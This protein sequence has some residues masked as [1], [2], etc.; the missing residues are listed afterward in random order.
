MGAVQLALFESMK[1][2]VINSRDIDFDVN[3]LL[4]EAL[5]GS[6]GGAIGAFISTPG[7]IVTIQL[8]AGLDNKDDE[9]DD[10]ATDGTQFDR[11]GTSYAGSMVATDFEEVKSAAE[12]ALRVYNE[13]GIGAFFEGAKER[14]LYW[15]IAISIFLSVYCSLR[16]YAIDVM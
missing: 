6:I 5:F 4:A 7:D 15:S 12:V 1:S 3:T 9:S 8:M 16:R 13:K 14:V 2:F 11:V 10:T